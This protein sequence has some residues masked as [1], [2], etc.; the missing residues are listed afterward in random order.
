MPSP[1]PIGHALLNKVKKQDS[2]V[3]EGAPSDGGKYLTAGTVLRARYM[4]RG[5]SLK[6]GTGP[7]DHNC[8]PVS[9]SQRGLQELR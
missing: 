2:V 1:G 6:P 3:A 4:K 5:Q 7:R 9:S 8:Q